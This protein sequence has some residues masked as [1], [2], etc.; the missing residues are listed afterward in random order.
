MNC[1]SIPHSEPPRTIGV[2]N[3]ILA[4]GPRTPLAMHKMRAAALMIVL[5]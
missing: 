5:R 2:S 3:T 1:G 4:T